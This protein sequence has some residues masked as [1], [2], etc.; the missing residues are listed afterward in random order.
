MTTGRTV[1]GER[2]QGTVHKRYRLAGNSLRHGIT[3]LLLREGT[4]VLQEVL[5]EEDIPCHQNK[6]I[7]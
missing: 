5:Q 6:D 1:R 4:A 7:S 3:A 2:R